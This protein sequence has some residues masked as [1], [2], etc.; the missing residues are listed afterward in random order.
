M[1]LRKVGHRVLRYEARPTPCAQRANVARAATP[2]SLP[3]EASDR[4]RRGPCLARR[5]GRS[6][7]P[8]CLG[9]QEPVSPLISCPRWTTTKRLAFPWSRSRFVQAEH[10]RSRWWRARS[11]L[12]PSGSERRLGGAASFRAGA[13]VLLRSPGLARLSERRP[14]WVA[15]RRRRTSPSRE[16][17]AR[18]V[19][20]AA[21]QFH[22]RVRSRPVASAFRQMTRAWM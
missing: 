2:A 8:L 7:R 14:G 18:R 19:R 4:H 12:V 3:A 21:G 16:A 17:R 10:A 13:T 6:G 1:T 15:V 22:E 20:R 11:E 5:G 9:E